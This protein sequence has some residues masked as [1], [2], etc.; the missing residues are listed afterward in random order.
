MGKEDTV[1]QK[2]KIF[3]LVIFHL[4]VT[5]LTLKRGEGWGAGDLL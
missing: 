3:N 5:N 2:L 1:L 4:G